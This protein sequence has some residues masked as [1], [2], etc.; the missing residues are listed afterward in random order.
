M[1]GDKL[2]ILGGIISVSGYVFV[3]NGIVEYLRC[4]VAVCFPGYCGAVIADIRDGDIIN[5]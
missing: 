3:R 4:G 2:G 5:C 1:L